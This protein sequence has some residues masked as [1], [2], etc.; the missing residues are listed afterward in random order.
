MTTDLDRQL[1]DYFE[2]INP[3]LEVPGAGEQA[4]FASGATRK[5]WGPTMAL[6]AAVLVLVLIGGIVVGA[7]LLREDAPVTDQTPPPST[8]TTLP[9]TS[10]TV[11]GTSSTVPT[12]VPV[13]TPVGGTIWTAHYGAIA[14]GDDIQVNSVDATSYGLIATGFEFTHEECEA[15][16]LTRDG[17]VWLSSDG[18]KWTQSPH[19]FAPQASPRSLVE[20]EDRL[21]MGGSLPSERCYSWGCL[22][23]QALW[24]SDDGGANWEEL[25][26]DREVFGEVSGISKIIPGG[27]G[28]LAIGSRCPLDG[29]QCLFEDET[30]VLLELRATMWASDSG[31]DWQV[32]HQDPVGEVHDVTA[33]GGGYVA[34][35]GRCGEE[36]IGAVCTSFAWSSADGITW[37]RVERLPGDLDLSSVTAGGPGLVATGSYI[38]PPPE[39]DISQVRVLTSDDGLNWTLAELQEDGS[40]LEVKSFEG[41]VIGVGG[42]FEGNDVAVSVWRSS[43]GN[44]W[45]RVAID[46][47]QHTGLVNHVAAMGSR[48]VVVTSSGDVY[49][50]DPD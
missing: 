5:T 39:L 36:G 30:G 19:R 17:R 2:H 7:I 26:F 34:V 38:P 20:L 11:P 37:T 18:V 4:V 41:T 14:R 24:T 48:L 28:L 21:L 33:W 16:N 22:R 32:V 23:R 50:S 25:P 47:G 45:E 1:R 49:V 10:S 15:C 43:D 8:E 31:T 27:P 40:I 9:T 3:P 42:V 35:G 13:P 29:S 6:A 46:V 44:A 12:T